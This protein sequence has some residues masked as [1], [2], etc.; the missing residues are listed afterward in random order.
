[1]I[2]QA[3]VAI[4]FIIITLAYSVCFS[5][6]RTIELKLDEIVRLLKEERGKYGSK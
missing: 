5:R 1:M 3:I 6:I 4:I 2:D